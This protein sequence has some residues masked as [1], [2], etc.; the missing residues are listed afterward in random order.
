MTAQQEAALA[1]RQTELD[2]RISEVDAMLARQ[3]RAEAESW[4]QDQADAGRILPRHAAPLSELTAALAALS[5]QGDDDAG[6]AVMLAA[7]DDD[8]GD[9]QV[10]AADWLRSFVESLPTQIDYSERSGPGAEPPG[11]VAAFAATGADRQGL[12]ERAL[13][14]AAKQDVDYQIALLA[15]ADEAAR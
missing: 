4:A 7:T 11:Q 9:S 10:A 3:R 12:H 1:A 8:G 5:A 2:R 13:A 15:A 6:D 14:I